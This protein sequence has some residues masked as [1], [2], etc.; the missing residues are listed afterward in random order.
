MAQPEIS[1]ILCT[2]NPRGDYLARVLKALR[3]QTMPL[4]QWELL[5][6]DNA[7]EDPVAD[8]FD[9]SWHPN[10]RHVREDKLGLTPARLR[11]IADSDAELLMFVDDDNVLLPDYLEQ[12]LRIGREFPFLGT[13]GGSASPEFDVPPEPWAIP[14]FPLLALRECVR[15]S[16]SNA[17]SHNECVPNGA[18]MCVRRVV[19]NAYATKATTDGLHRKLGRRGNDLA[20]HEDQA[21]VFTGCQMGFGAGSMV[22]LRLIHL[23]PARRLSRSYLLRLEEGNGY[24]EILLAHSLGGVVPDDP[25]VSLLGRAVRWCRA[26]RKPR[27]ERQKA[28]ARRRGRMEGLR[29]ISRLS[30]ASADH[31]GPVRDAQGIRSSIGGLLFEN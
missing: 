27:F 12:G 6:V 30:Q 14:S 11:G 28:E 26:F 4:D 8:R 23:I 21:L 10:G 13:W 15:D 20:G 29:A 18:G 19:A 24:S 3:A 9:I 7:S 22:S 25:P 5:V 16:W 17:L 2:H 31:D 1:V